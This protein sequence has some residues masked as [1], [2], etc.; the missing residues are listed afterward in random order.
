MSSFI[1]T[2]E[3]EWKK[4]ISIE[5]TKE[6]RATLSKPDSEETKEEKNT[7][8]E[9]LKAK[10][11]ED[12]TAKELKALKAK[13]TEVKSSLENPDNKEFALI[14]CNLFDA[15]EG[16]FIGSIGY[17]LDGYFFIKPVE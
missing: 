11:I 2:K 6:E 9:A 7:L 12:V 17:T 3:G 13:Y 10:S 4:A 16:K 5:L 8:I 15:G 1:S 14:S